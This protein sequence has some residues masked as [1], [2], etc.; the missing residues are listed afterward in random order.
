MPKLLNS[1]RRLLA[2]ALASVA[3]TAWAGAYDDLM[4]AANNG[5]TEQVVELVQKGM[6]VNTTDQEGNSLLMIAVRTDNAP[7]VDFLLQHRAGVGRRNR[8]GDDAL[9]IAAY[10]G[11]LETVKKLV[12]AGAEIQHP[13]WTALHYAAI[14]GLPDMAAYL[15]DKGAAVDAKAP[16]GQT[17]LMLAANRNQADLVQVLLA[18]KADLGITDAD[19]K[20]AADMAA[21]QGHEDLAKLLTQTR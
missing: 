5:V 20:T 8:Y 21:A 6:D 17:A 4:M 18:K 12:A 1:L 19:G 13:G 7:L 10:S 11:Q 15:V 3:C 16:N 2:V 9:M 14:Q